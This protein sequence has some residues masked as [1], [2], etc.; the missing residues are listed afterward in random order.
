MSDEKA[1]VDAS[2]NIAEALVKGLGGIESAIKSPVR[3]YGG[4]HPPLAAADIVAGAVPDTGSTSPLVKAL[5]HI[6]KAIEGL[7][8]AV[9]AG[10][11]GV[12]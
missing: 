11:G 12:A 4:R 3:E 8:G 7:A 2:R 6:A 10:K 9:Q 1:L 5:E